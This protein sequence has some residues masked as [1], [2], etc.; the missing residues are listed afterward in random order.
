M[1]C[2]SVGTFYNIHSL[3]AFWTAEVACRYPFRS[4]RPRIA[5]ADEERRRAPAASAA[6][7]PP[8]TAPPSLPS[9]LPTIANSPD[10][11]PV[12]SRNASGLGQGGEATAASARPVLTLAD[13][14]EITGRNVPESSIG[15]ETT[16]IVCMSQPKTHLAVPCGHQC[17]CGA[18]A[19]QMQQCPYCRA[20]VQKWIQVRVV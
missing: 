1:F 12:A 17:A 6:A 18:C 20:P 16:C 7:L 15:G 10:T 3:A 14:G 19:E 11:P 5:E 9:P 2:G 8:A 13:V 4:R